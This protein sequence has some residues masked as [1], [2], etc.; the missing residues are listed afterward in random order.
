[1]RV[2]L[3]NEASLISVY[4]KFYYIIDVSYCIKRKLQSIFRQAVILPKFGVPFGAI[5]LA[6][7]ILEEFH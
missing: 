5:L 2:I 3:L 7:M 4:K 6:L 1:M